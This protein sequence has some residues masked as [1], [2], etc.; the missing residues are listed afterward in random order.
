MFM[1]HMHVFITMSQNQEVLKIHLKKLKDLLTKLICLTQNG[2]ASLKME[3]LTI[4]VI[5][6]RS[7]RIAGC[8]RIILYFV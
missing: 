2:E 6:L 4:I 8:D 3:I 1:H 5:F 7:I